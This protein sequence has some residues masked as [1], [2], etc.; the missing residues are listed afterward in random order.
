[1]FLTLSLLYMNKKS[2]IFSIIAI[3]II[4]IWWT[5]FFNKYSENKK[6]EQLANKQAEIKEEMKQREI[7][8]EKDRTVEINN[9][10]SWSGLSKDLTLM[11]LKEYYLL[12]WTGWFTRFN[13]PNNTEEQSIHPIKIIKVQWKKTG[14]NAQVAFTVQN[15]LIPYIMEEYADDKIKLYVQTGTGEKTYIDKNNQQLRTSIE[16]MYDKFDTTI[17][18]WFWSEDKTLIEN[19]L[20]N[21]TFIWI[22]GKWARGYH[23]DIFDFDYKTTIKLLDN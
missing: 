22:E 19:I 20:K 9:E 1:M 15:L 10:L 4:V 21:A 2:I 14:Y 5:M 11:Q 7:Q 8:Y 12:T 3:I 6:V 18:I 17:Y 23:K 16:W 13:K